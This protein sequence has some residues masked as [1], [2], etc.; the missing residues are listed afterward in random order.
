MLPIYR[1]ILRALALSYLLDGLIVTADSVAVMKSD[2][3]WKAIWSVLL[4]VALTFRRCVIDGVAVFLMQHG[5]HPPE[6]LRL[7]DPPPLLS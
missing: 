2:K 4:S 3:I 7:S 1:S 6:T 5:G